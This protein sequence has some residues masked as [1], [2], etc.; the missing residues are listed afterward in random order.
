MEKGLKFCWIFISDC[1]P[2]VESQPER[3]K[4]KSP[5]EG[6]RLQQK[7]EKDSILFPLFQNITK[8]FYWSRALML[9]TDIQ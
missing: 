9:Y 1:V 2:T 5:K 3:H 7:P 8:S 4:G 6:H